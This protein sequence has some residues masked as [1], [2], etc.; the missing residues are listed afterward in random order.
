MKILK[1]VKGRKAQKGQYVVTVL[2]DERELFELGAPQTEMKMA[3]SDLSLEA[4]AFKHMEA[5]YKTGI[6][7]IKISE[8]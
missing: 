4:E 7:L 8:V 6:G 3:V 2:V 5:Y 1:A